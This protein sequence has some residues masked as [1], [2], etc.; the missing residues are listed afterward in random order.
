MKSSIDIHV[1]SAELFPWVKVGGLGDVVGALYRY[2]PEEGFNVTCWLPYSYELASSDQQCIGNRTFSFRDE[3]IASRLYCLEESDFGRVFAVE[4]PGSAQERIYQ[5]SDGHALIHKFVRFSWCVLKWMME[6]GYETGVLHI[7]DW[8]TVP[9]LLFGRCTN[10]FPTLRFHK[11]ILTIHNLA[12]QGTFDL[13]ERETLGLDLCSRSILEWRGKGNL[14]K[15]GILMCDILTTV[16]PRYALEI[17]TPEFGEGLEEVLRQKKG[18]KGILNGI[19]T[20]LWDPHRDPYIIAPYNAEDF[21][22]KIE[23]KKWLIQEF[24]LPISFDQP[25]FGFVSR[26]TFQKGIDRFID[27]LPELVQYGACVGLG[28]G[29]A[30]YEMKLQALVHELDGRFRMINRYDE[31]LAHRIEAGC[32]FFL[33]PSR[34]E[35]C[36][37]NQMY[38]MRYG[39]IPLVQ[40]VG[41]LLDTVHDVRFEPH[42]GTGWVVKEDAVSS[43][44]GVLKDCA[45]MYAYEKAF[46]AIRRRGMR[47]DFSWRRPIKEYARLYRN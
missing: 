24:Q 22:G 35:P 14:L 5:A 9:V 11:T 7:H 47:Q 40:G 37:L 13:N 15:A 28:T 32:D 25:L 1:C 8:H 43:W 23:N 41:G 17:Q 6:Q 30:E 38:S 16:S 2:L 46:E 3:N 10:A 19:D 18:I 27:I 45:R 44:Y 4:V 34:F 33:M 21:R 31:V 39:T 29:D 12:Y 26:L 36:G 42:R 20:T